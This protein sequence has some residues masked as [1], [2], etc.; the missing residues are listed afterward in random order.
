[1]RNARWRDSPMPTPRDRLKRE[2]ARSSSVG[3]STP[4]GRRTAVMVSER[5]PGFPHVD[6]GSQD[7]A[8][9][10]VDRRPDGTNIGRHA[11][12]RLVVHHEYG[13]ERR[14][15]GTQAFFHVVRPDLL[16]PVEH[17]VVNFKAQPTRGIAKAQ[18]ELSIDARQDA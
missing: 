15:A 8:A 14:S 3:P 2:R 4:S 9:G 18:S 11:G 16:A 17:Q 10:A 5:K 12:R 1:M 7:A 13:L 6:G